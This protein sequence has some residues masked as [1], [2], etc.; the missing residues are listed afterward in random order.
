MR[1]MRRFAWF[2][3]AVTFGLTWAGI[4]L[5][6]E[7]GPEF[8]SAVYFGGAGD[9]G[10]VGNGMGLAADGKSIYLAAVDRALYGGQ[11]LAVKYNLPLGA[12][13]V[14]AFRWP[15]MP[16]N[17]W[18]DS[19]VFCDVA[20]TSEGIYCAGRSWVQSTDGVG[21]KENKA[22]LV[23]FPLEG[24]AGPAVGGAL[25]VAKPLFFPNYVG[26]ETFLGVLPLEE[27]GSTFLYA[28]G[29][30]QANW[31]NNTAVV[32]KLD[33]QGKH[34][35]TRVLG[36]TGWNRGSNA[37]RM[38]ALNGHIYVAGHTHYH[39]G[40][41]NFPQ[42]FGLWKVDPSGNLIWGRMSPE[43]IHSVGNMPIG[44]VAFA[45]H[46][47]V[48]TAKLNGTQ[49][50]YD[51]W[52]LKYDEA[53]NLVSN[54]TWGS[55]RDDV[56]TAITVVKDRLYVVGY[57]AGW[58]GGGKDAFLLEMNAQ[59]CEVS[60]VNYH[61]GQNDD[62]A[63]GVVSAG[64]DLYIV[65][66]T[67]SFEQGGNAAG[68]SD[69]MLLRYALTREPP[70][71]TVP[72]DIKPGHHPNPVNLRSKGK[73]PVAI[74]STQEFLAAEVV[75]R[76]SLSFGRLGDEKS[77]LPGR[78]QPE[79]VNGDSLL[80]LVCHFVTQTAGFQVGDTRGILKGKTLE[81]RPF[82]GMD[83]VV[84]V[85]KKR[86]LKDDDKDDDKW[87]K[88]PAPI[89]PPAREETWKE[90]KP[91]PAPKAE[92]PKGFNPPAGELKKIKKEGSVVY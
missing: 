23:K 92:S 90:M 73:I 14:W 28:C 2:L 37:I 3:F 68:Q 21:G 40:K 48:A 42:S 77:L 55:T 85:P 4:G 46:L 32:A 33:T 39:D 54:H 86:E 47:F 91:V 67:R 80:D 10:Y 66:E 27:G 31:A 59:T 52:V 56:A 58:V 89:K 53:G 70:F 51:V 84:I 34:L 69:L 15:N 88:S 6:E 29:R 78:V 76:A 19:E 8:K 61:G 38:A 36:D 65:G 87:K 17:N 75:D 11:A 7:K 35:W 26:L 20:V 9:Q 71:L 83:S 49:G 16:A 72:I 64:T 62:A 30:G 1:G 25:W 60:S 5:A 45:N 13:L 79:D 81:G 24:P 50:G 41:P 74:L 63:F 44:L 82:L 12:S 22:V 43:P 18:W 57:T